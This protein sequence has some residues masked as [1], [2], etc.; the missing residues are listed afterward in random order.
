MYSKNLE[1]GHVA[2]LCNRVQLELRI[3]SR[4]ESRLRET[5]FLRMIRSSKRCSARRWRSRGYQFT[6]I[7]CWGAANPLRPRRS[8][9]ETWYTSALYPDSRRWR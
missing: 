4:F 9:P 7:T 1:R 8:V 6:Y 5:G 2:Q 3:L